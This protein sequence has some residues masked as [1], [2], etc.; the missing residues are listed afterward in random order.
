M[1]G[2]TGFF[3]KVIN[4]PA[5]EV[6][7]LSIEGFGSIGPWNTE[8]S[9]LLLYYRESPEDPWTLSLYSPDSGLRELGSATDAVHI[10]HDFSP[11]GKW[12]VYAS[13]EAA[14]EFR[15]FARP[16]PGLGAS[17][18]ISGGKETETRPVWSRDGSRIFYKTATDTSVVVWEV[19]IT[20]EEDRITPG[21]PK[22]LFEGQYSNHSPVRAWDVGPD[23][24]F[25]MLRNLPD[26]PDMKAWTYGPTRIRLVQN[27]F[28]ELKEMVG[29]SE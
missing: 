8:G 28:K 22:R 24:R 4:A 5:S 6:K 1:D 15:V 29:A 19:S 23:G 11:D 25:L 27:S 14:E 13:T 17:V 3:T 16:F 7:R 9:H 20:V 21:K 12:I 26:H 18:Q 2:K 10:W